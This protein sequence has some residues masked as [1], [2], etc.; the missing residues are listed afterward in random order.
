MRIDTI[1]RIVT[2]LGASVDLTLRWR[3]EQLDRLADAAHAQLVQSVVA[4]LRSAGWSVHVEVSFNHYGDRGRVDVLALWPP[5]GLV[6]VVE[7]KTALGDLQETLG[8]LDVKTRLGATIAA[9]VGS[10]AAQAV[11]PGL[12]IGDTR[13]SRR[14]VVEHTALFTRYE[15]RGRFAIAWLR[16]PTT[17]VPSGL[18]WF[19]KLPDSHRVTATRERRV[20]TVDLRP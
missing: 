10:S 3:G 9:S 13:R 16:R 1:E 4:D 14:V 6:L 5:L 2:A 12:V 11:V 15:R 7:V 8:R 18:L 17:P 19:A 20:R